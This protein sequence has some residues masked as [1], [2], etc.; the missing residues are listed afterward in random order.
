VGGAVGVC[1]EGGFEAAVGEDCGVDAAGEFAEFLEGVGE[2][3]AGAL[4]VGVVGVAAGGESEHEG[5]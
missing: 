5:E 3:V 4:E 1:A 2:F